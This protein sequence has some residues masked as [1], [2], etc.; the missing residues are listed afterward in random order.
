[1][2]K[3]EIMLLHVSTTFIIIVLQNASIN[4][5]ILAPILTSKPS[6]GVQLIGSW[7]QRHFTDLGPLAYFGPVVPHRLLY[8]AVFPLNTLLQLA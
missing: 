3:W 4:K 2:D 6:V 1:M 8:T 7:R 5:N